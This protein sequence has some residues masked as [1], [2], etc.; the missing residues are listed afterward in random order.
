M[1]ARSQ[2]SPE[3]IAR[4]HR[5]FI[6]HVQ[7][8]RQENE[9]LRQQARQAVSQAIT[10]VAD[11]YPTVQ[12]VYL[13]GSVIRP[14]AFQAGSDV[15]VGIEGATMARCFD[16]WRD[17]EQVVSEWSLDVRALDAQDPFSE[18]IRQKGELI[19]ERAVPTS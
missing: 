14:G 7:R 15:D 2:L 17:L 10:E 3:S 16:I 11:R 9:K 5:S 1:K 8:R 4:Y 19:Y 6:K 13:F 18:R 12:R